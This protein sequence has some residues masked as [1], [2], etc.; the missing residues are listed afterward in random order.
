MRAV[1]AGSDCGPHGGK[2]FLPPKP[3][4]KI[5]NFQKRSPALKKDMFTRKL[6]GLSTPCSLGVLLQFS[7]R[8]LLLLPPERCFCSGSIRICECVPMSAVLLPRPSHIALRRF[9]LSTRLNSW[10][11]S[12]GG[13]PVMPVAGPRKAE[14]FISSTSGTF[15]SVSRRWPGIRRPGPPPLFQNLNKNAASWAFP[16]VTE[17][18]I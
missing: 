4:L 5:R 2:G 3:T 12:A 1:S 14:S 6:L 17:S 15:A 13:Q 16:R 8:C 11:R 9:P 18:K 10:L 7:L